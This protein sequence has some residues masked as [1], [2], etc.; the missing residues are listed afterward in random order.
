[1]TVED[2][3]KLEK[4]LKS[5]QGKLDIPIETIIEQVETFGKGISPA[6]IVKACTI[7][8]GIKIIPEEYFN[9]YFDLFHSALDSERIIKF[10]PASGAASRMFKK[11]QSVLTK[12]K[13]TQKEL[14]KSANSGDEESSSVLEFINNLE[15]FAFYDDLMKKMEEAGLKL[16][17]LK[18]NGEFEKIIKFTLEP[19]GLDYSAKPK[20]CI[21]FHNY[22]EGSRTAFE[23]HLVEAIN[24]TKGKDGPAN[25]HFTISAE[26]EELVKSIIDPLLEKYSKEGK[27]IEVSYSFQKKSTNTVAATADNK[28]FRDEDGKIVFRPGGHG[29][30]LSNLNDM[31]ADIIVIKN[32]DNLVPDHFRDE[33]YKYKKLLIG[34]LVEIH[35]KLIT[36]IE[37]LEQKNISDELLERIKNFVKNDLEIHIAEEYKSV[38]SKNKRD[39]LFRLMNRPIRIC[40]MVKKEEHPGGG[41]FWVSERDGTVT[42]QVVE[43]TQIDLNNKEQQDIF[44]SATH[45]SPVDFICCVRD[46][47]NKPFDLYRFSDKDSGL[48]T[49]KSKDGKEL[50]ALELPG[51]WN[52]GM[53][54]WITLIVEV[55]KITFNPVK[56]VNDLL[57]AE[58]QPPKI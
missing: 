27:L 45:F 39:Y 56:E 32:I 41:P 15:H 20:G 35:S 9:K 31:K 52:G 30:L 2:K 55:P 16:A 42:K 19:V 22:P 21:K 25:I 57:K 4:E 26:H 48:I 47:K 51:L 43:T 33:T 34:Y 1:M 5:E 40:G 24:Y 49:I 7:D 12:S 17:K 46:Y 23:E 14:E 8:D 36:Y 44:E 38:D 6:R 50:K 54:N 58:H 53:A 13:K 18:Q 10:V 29:A 3:K 28:P 11:L 37:Q